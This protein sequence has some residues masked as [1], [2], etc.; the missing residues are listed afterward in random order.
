MGNTQ[1]SVTMH[2]AFITR[3]GGPEV[4]QT[5]QLVVPE[6]GPTDVLVQLQATTV[7]H[8][9]T[10]VRSGAYPTH[11]VFPFILGRDLVGTVIKVGPGVADFQIGD[12]VWTNSMGYDGRQGTFAQYTVVSTDRLYR[13]PDGVEAATAAP[14]LHSA[15]TAYFGLV[16][17]AQLFAGETV[18]VGGAA[19][20]VGSSVDQLASIMGARVIASASPRDHQWCEELGAEVVFDYHMDNLKDKLGAAAPEGIDIWWDTSG[21]YDFETTLPLLAERARIL[22]TASMDAAPSLPLGQ[23]YTRDIRICGFA[24]SQATVS[25]LAAAADMINILLRRGQLRGRIGPKFRLSDTAQAHRTME[26]GES[27]GRILIT[28]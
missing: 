28:P 13:L 7:N 17:E 11:L 16:R 8:V 23:L 24:M 19:G 21:H 22:V 20:G 3:T 9:D 5:G 6:I 15:A 10:F 2:G 25:D 4:I 12:R 1:Q 26:N 14:V 18:F 27:R